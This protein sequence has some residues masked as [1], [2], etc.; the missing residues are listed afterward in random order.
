MNIKMKHIGKTSLSINLAKHYNTEIVSARKGITISI[1]FFNL[2]ER[3]HDILLGN[4]DYQIN[5]NNES[6]SLAV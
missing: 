2:E 5:F 3:I 4:V 1:K 6:S